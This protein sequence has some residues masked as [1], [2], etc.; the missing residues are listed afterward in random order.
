MLISLSNKTSQFFIDFEQQFIN[1]NLRTF[2]KVKNNS[3]AILKLTIK[4]TF[5]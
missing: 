4:I 5:K 2:V 1:G 3:D